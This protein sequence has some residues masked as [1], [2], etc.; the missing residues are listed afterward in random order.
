MFK[1]EKNMKT[2]H[3]YFYLLNFIVLFLIVLVLLKKI[4]NRGK[5]YVILDTIYQFSI[6]L[7]IY[8][9]VVKFLKLIISNGISFI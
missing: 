3:F 7:F 4:K 1:I 9:N 6:G 5:I 8:L 2:Y